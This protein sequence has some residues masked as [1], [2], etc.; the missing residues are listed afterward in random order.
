MRWYRGPNDVPGASG[1][2]APKARPPVEVP[3]RGP[4]VSSIPVLMRTP[5]LA[6]GGGVSCVTASLTLERPG[7]VIAAESGPSDVAASRGSV[8]TP[9]VG[10]RLQVGQEAAP[11]G[12]RAP[13]CGQNIKV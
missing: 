1:P 8:T 6:A 12:R 3:L 9:S 10:A 5:E 13:Q 2:V 11:S 7:S 4:I